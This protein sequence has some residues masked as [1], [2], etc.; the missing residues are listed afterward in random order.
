[1]F[2]WW[3]CAVVDE[4]PNSFYM[5][6]QQLWGRN[7]NSIYSHSQH[8]TDTSHSAW[9][10]K[11]RSNEQWPAQM[12]AITKT[13]NKVS[14]LLLLLPAPVTESIRPQRRTFWSP[15]VMTFWR[16]HLSVLIW[17]LRPARLD[18]PDK[19]TVC[20]GVWFNITGESVR[21]ITLQKVE[22]NLLL[23]CMK[24]SVYYHIIV[25]HP[26]VLLSYVWRW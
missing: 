6:R 25:T 9:S 10:N 19:T 3:K 4:P 16:L 18:W 5:K 12:K 8:L 13:I 1:M 21:G 17:K 7:N 2:W 24:Y 20:V 23:A 26:S 22:L 11:R 14:I 15:N